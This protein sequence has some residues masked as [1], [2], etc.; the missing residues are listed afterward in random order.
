MAVP[1]GLALGHVA[2]GDFVPDPRRA[3]E[4]LE[5]AMSIAP[6]GTDVPRQP[7]IAARIA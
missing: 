5:G 4:A 1:G 3:L 6:A 7:L 2:L